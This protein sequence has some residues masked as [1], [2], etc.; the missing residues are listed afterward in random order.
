MKRVRKMN[1]E[2]KTVQAAFAAAL[3][4]LTYYLGMVAVPIVVLMIAMIIDYVTGMVSAWHKAELSSKKGIFGI[5]KKISYLGLVCV[6]MGVD[7]LIYSGLH[8]VGVDL[9]YTI[10]FGVLVTIWLI[11]NEL[12]SILENLGTIGVPLPK[13]L[14][15]V[16]KKLKTTAENKIESEDEKDD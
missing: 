5:V 16:V 4:M 6:G 8:S 14:L 13:F 11:I 12:I 9:G 7:W 3:T 2:G 1:I 15:T 10:F